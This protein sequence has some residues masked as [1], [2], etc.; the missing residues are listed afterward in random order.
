MQY[1]GT[2]N[3]PDFHEGLEWLNTDKPISMKD[4]KGKV[5]LLDF[6]T[7]CCINC[8]HVI[9]DLKKLEEEFA[10]ELVVIGVHSA[11]FENE[12]LTENIREAVLRY[13]IEH[14]V[15]N[16]KD[17]KVWREYGARAWPSFA[18]INPRGKLL[19]L[20]S[21]EGIYLK[22]RDVIEE[23]ITEFDEL[24]EI[25]RT[26]LN[27]TL[28]N[29]TRPKSVLNYPGKISFDSS[30]N[31]LW[32]SDSNNNRIIGL[33]QNGNP[34]HIIGNGR[35]GLK[36]GDFKTAEFLGLRAFIIQLKMTLFIL[37][38]LKTMLYEK[39]ILKAKQLPE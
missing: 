25:D 17:F 23:I 16:D 29:S 28:E 27:L 34:V 12:K 24:G 30:R 38:I 33:D 11:K 21:G 5:V 9:P 7:Y 39:L 20:T 19:G 6:W 36:D 26:P 8:I 35:I 1:A 3:A 15:V 31:L 4:L 13:E 37:L 14:P 22:I 32:I 10:D 2:V 18:L